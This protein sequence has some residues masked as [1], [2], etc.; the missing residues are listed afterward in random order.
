[1]RGVT[2]YIMRQIAWPLVFATL[3]L[4]GVIWLTQALRF[5]DRIVNNNLAFLDFLYLTLLVLPSVVA[6][7]LP[8][9][10]FCAA[11]YAFNRLASD[12]EIVVLSSTGFSRI[13]L[14]RPAIYIAMIIM[15]IMY[16][17]TLYLMPLGSRTLRTTQYEFRNDLAGMVLLEGVFN[18]PTDKLTVYIR[19]RDANG[20]MQGVL[21]HDN[22]NGVQPI[23]MM[24]EKATLLRTPQGPRLYMVNGNRQQIDAER[25]SLSLLYFDNYSLDLDSYSQKEGQIWREPSERFLSEL[26]NPDMQNPDDVRNYNKLIV[27]GHRRLVTP[28]YAPALILIAIASVIGGEFNRRGQGQR[29]IVGGAIAIVLQILSLGVSHL[30]A[31]S[32]ILIPLLYLTPLAF[33]A[34]AIFM[35]REPALR[36]RIQA[37]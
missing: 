20:D 17:I 26:F 33:L 32:I 25:K 28:L 9:A 18:T 22:R 16:A 30:A 13:A 14:A 11:L 21:V 4:T 1:M 35:L 3:T 19:E 12:S 7:I 31:K 8:I 27:E 36:T 24:A 5:I 37:A 2:T 23:T 34:A 29:L 10:A 15:A 6:I